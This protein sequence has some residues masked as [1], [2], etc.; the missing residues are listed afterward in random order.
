MTLFSIGAAI[1]VAIAVWAFIEIRAMRAYDR[2]FEE[3]TG[4][5]RL[6][7][8]RLDEVTGSLGPPYMPANQAKQ[9]DFYVVYKSLHAEYASIAFHEGRVVRVSYSWQ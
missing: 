3:T 8:K 4:L 6:E 9:G 2:H 7:G 1:V 5:A